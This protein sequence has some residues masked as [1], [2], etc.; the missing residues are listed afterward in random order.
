MENQLGFRFI[1]PATVK[2]GPTTAKGD[3]QEK[4]AASKF[5]LAIYSPFSC[6]RTADE[7]HFQTG[8]TLDPNRAANHASDAN[9]P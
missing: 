7:N 8:Y 2:P 9:H 5:K 6:G 4:V 3:P 1:E